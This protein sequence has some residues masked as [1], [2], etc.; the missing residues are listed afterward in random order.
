VSV[1]AVDCRGN[2]ASATSTS[3]WPWSYPGRLGDSPV[4]GAGNYADNRA[5]AVACTGAGELAI[6]CCTA[7]TAVDALG[8]GFAVEDACKIALDDIATLSDISHRTLLMN[9]V[10]VDAHGNHCAI[11]TRPRIDYVV[12]DDSAPVVR[13]LPRVYYSP[14]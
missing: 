14:G 12:R 11:S 1:V 4:I 5:G 7:R 3:G 6:R 2:V 10:A 8:R 9:L 13:R